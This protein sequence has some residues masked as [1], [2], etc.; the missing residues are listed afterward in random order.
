MQYT[1]TMPAFSRD[2]SI[3]KHMVNI[4]LD[5]ITCKKFIK[6]ESSRNQVGMQSI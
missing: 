1:T 3:H 4:E 6:L 5:S 2:Y